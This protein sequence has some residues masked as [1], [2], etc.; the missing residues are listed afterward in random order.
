MTVSLSKGGN[1]SL[2]KE[3]PGLTEVTI[4]LGWDERTTDGAA[5]DLDASAFLVNATGKVNKDQDF[6][7]Y[8]NLKSL[9]ESVTHTGDN[10]TGEGE[11]DDESLIVALDKVPA[12]VDRVVFGTTIHEAEKLSQSFGQVRNASIRIVDNRDGT[13]IARYDLSEDY[14]TETAMLM[15]ELYRHD[16]SWKFRALG[17]GYEGG[18]TKMALDHGVN[19]A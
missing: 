9:C 1:V 16:G 2:E 11:G 10:R 14:S 13:E 8:N 7:F 12:D 4:G 19:L 5:F 18:L 6:I 3:A 15:G 17:S